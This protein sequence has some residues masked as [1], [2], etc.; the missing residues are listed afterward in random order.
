[1]LVAVAALSVG[2]GRADSGTVAGTV[3][4]NGGAMQ[5]GATAPPFDNTPM[6]GVVITVSTEAGRP[7]A[8]ATAAPD[9]AYTI[10]LRHGRYRISADC[11]SGRTTPVTVHSGSATEANLVCQ[12][13]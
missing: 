12:I 13:P 6:S 3:V 8:Y 1:M 5:A 9:G 2:C 7:T 11:D 10:R 4:G